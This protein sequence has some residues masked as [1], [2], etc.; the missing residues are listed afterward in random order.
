[1]LRIIPNWSKI[2]KIASLNAI[3]GLF[4]TPYAGRINVEK[5]RRKTAGSDGKSSEGGG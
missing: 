2:V 3:L 1:M 5:I 4:E